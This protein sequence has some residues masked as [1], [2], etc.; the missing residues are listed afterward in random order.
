MNWR[1]ALG[2]T[3]LLGQLAWRGRPA[4]WAP[5][6]QHA[7]YSLSVDVAGQHLD[8]AA[9][10]ERYHLP[11]WHSAPSRDENWETNDLQFVKDVIRAAE[12][13]G[14]VELRARINGEEQPAWRW[15]R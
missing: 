6:H 12:T 2:L 14:T 11:K 13:T 1:L 8:T 4:L 5:F 15:P 3:L 7:V 9:A 10:L